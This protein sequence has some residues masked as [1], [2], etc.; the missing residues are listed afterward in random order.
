MLDYFLYLWLHCT[1]SEVPVKFKFLLFS[2][3]KVWSYS[4]Q[5]MCMY[6][7]CL[8]YVYLLLKISLLIITL[9][10]E[11]CMLS[12]KKECSRQNSILLT[13]YNYLQSNWLIVWLNNYG[14]GLETLWLNLMKKVVTQWRPLTNNYD[15]F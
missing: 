15:Y 2:P 10:K 11:N 3:N 1:C 12:S 8:L 5:H 6:K 7:V 4:M 9:I 13:S 14:N